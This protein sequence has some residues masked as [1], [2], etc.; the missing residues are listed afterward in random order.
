[1]NRIKL[2]MKW[3]LLALAAVSFLSSCGDN[4]DGPPPLPNYSEVIQGRYQVVRSY[5][6][7]FG[8]DEVF[9]FLDTVAIQVDR[10]S[11]GEV[12]FQ[13]VDNGFSFRATF[14]QEASDG[15]IFSI[16]DGSN[17]QGLPLVPDTGDEEIEAQHGIF[18]YPT[19]ENS[20]EQQQLI[21]RIRVQ[22]TEYDCESFDYQP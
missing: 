17:Y 14:V 1:M 12:R 16:I 3:C 5:K 11:E 13:Q 7:T 18:Y 6:V 22:G 20:D 19:Q 2:V 4:N 21:Y 15:A 8:A 9:T 10:V